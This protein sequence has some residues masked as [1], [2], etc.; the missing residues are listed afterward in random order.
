V[1][2]GPLSASGTPESMDEQE[3]KKKEYLDALREQM[4]GRS[5]LT[6]DFGQLVLSR[7]DLQNEVGSFEE[8]VKAAGWADADGDR[9]GLVRQ[10][11]KSVETEEDRAARQMIGGFFKEGQDCLQRGDCGSAAASWQKALSLAGV[12]YDR[13][14]HD[15]PEHVM[16]LEFA[17]RRDIAFLTARFK[18]AVSNV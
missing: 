18:S 7:A 16:E 17:R 8:L 2:V 13:L 12:Y 14:Q 11:V 6:D 10:F 5:G 3:T 15:N 1:P 9:Y 4:G